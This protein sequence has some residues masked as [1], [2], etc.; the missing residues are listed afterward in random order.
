MSEPAS[1]ATPTPTV[2]PSD[3]LGGLSASERSHWRL[4]GE[5]PS[6]APADGSDTA[7][8]TTSS[9][10]SADSSTAQPAEQ[11]AE[12]AASLQPASEPGASKKKANA[13]T[14]KAELSAE[15]LSLKA[16]RDALKAEVEAVRRPPAPD[17]APAASSPAP[18]TLERA[19]ASPDLSR[20]ALDEDG[21]F[22]AF[23]EAKVADY[24]RYVSRYEV[25]QA[26]RQASDAQS[27][28]AKRAKHAERLAA[29]WSEHPD[30]GTRL[31]DALMSAAPIELLEATAPK[32]PWNYA[33]QEILDSPQTAALLTY[34]ADHPEA[35]QE[36][37]ATRTPT[38]TLRVMARL[39]LRAT[40]PSSAT[41][42]SVG[43]TTTSAPAPPQTLGTR[44]SAPA[45]EV[46]AAVAAGDFAR[47]ASAM[48]AKERQR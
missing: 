32:G 2:A 40:T 45:N 37:A 18:V 30:L 5:F 29:V 14:R 43:K 24:V 25:A 15:I 4:T 10:V 26:Q 6:R 34:L 42:Q 22:A 36:I 16:Q 27:Y 17:V 48:N 39:E 8:E 41:P 11:V 21:F 47:Y 13:D 23:P 35:V 46:E 44:P 7:T 19:L 38:E 31:P 12:S 20:P 9:D 33:A 3:V 1:V 28:Q